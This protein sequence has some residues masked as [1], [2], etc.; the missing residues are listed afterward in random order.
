MSRGGSQLVN[1]LVASNLAGSRASGLCVD[2]ASPHLL[3]TTI[4]RNTGGDGS[5]VSV[6]NTYGPGAVVMTNTVLVSHTV[7]I[8]VTAGSTAMLEATLWGSGPWANGADWGGDGTVITGTLA[9]NHWGE[10]D[11]VAPGNGDYHIDA[12]SS[13]IDKGISVSISTDIDGEPRLGTPDLGADEYWAPGAL[14]RVYLP[15]VLRQ[16]P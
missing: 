6:V 8:S 14:K 11:F 7:G 5:G 12:S 3:H 4:A 10:P 16:Y 13:A 15:L 1:T 9:N 2:S